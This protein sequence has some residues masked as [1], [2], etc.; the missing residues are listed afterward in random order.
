MPNIASLL[1]A[2]I[3][4]VA[5]KQVRSEIE[6]LRSASTQYRSAIA[7][8][9]KRVQSLERELARVRRGHGAAPASS[10]DE[11]GG[12]GPR[13]RFRSGGF[14][15]LRR[16]LG[17]SAADAGKLLNVTAQTVYAWEAGRTRPRQ[18]QLQAI[19]ELR[20]LGKR[21]VQRRLSGE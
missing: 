16:K 5:R 8:L 19:A 9:K 21:E 11:E 14:A 15:S 12:D 7:A 4:R 10:A 20:K 17:I 2:E 18:S 13:L 6:G 1:K 3:A